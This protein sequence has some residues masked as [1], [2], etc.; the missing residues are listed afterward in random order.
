[1]KIINNVNLKLEKL[2]YNDISPFVQ[3]IDP[4]KFSIPGRSYE[5]NSCKNNYNDEAKQMKFFFA[6]VEAILDYL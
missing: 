4:Y 6:L 5:L 3:L 1:V 2:F